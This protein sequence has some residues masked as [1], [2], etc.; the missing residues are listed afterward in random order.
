MIGYRLPFI[1]PE[2]NRVELVRAVYD[3]AMPEVACLDLEQLI[4]FA[5]DL[6]LH[7]YAT[8]SAC[9]CH[10]VICNYSVIGAVHHTFEVKY[11]SPLVSILKEVKNREE[12]EISNYDKKS[13][14]F[15]LKKVN[16]NN[17]KNEAINY[18]ELI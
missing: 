7:I 10:H 15:S 5:G 4:K 8:L 12:V 13:I 3:C 9:D 16:K 11:A 14:L 18:E 17:L 1:F 6:N 2:P